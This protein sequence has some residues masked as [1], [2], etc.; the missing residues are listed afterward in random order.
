LIKL[1][2]IL[3][4]SIKNNTMKIFCRPGNKIL[5]RFYLTIL[6][7]VIL[8]FTF[9]RNASAS[10]D[11]GKV[12]VLVTCQWL[13]ENISDPSIVILHISTVIKDYDNGHIQG[14]RFLWPGWLI[15][16]NEKESVVPAELK[17]MKKVLEGLGVNDR[18]HIVLCGIY[19]NIVTVCR[20]FMTLDHIGLGGRISIL[21]GGFDEW[22]DSGRKI[23]VEH[24]TS[25]KGKLVLSIQDNLVNTDWVAQNLTNKAYSVIS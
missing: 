2:G 9:T 23:S 15:V 4:R 16:S 11:N 1:G 24:P 21:E 6:F 8:V 18:S 12:P 5:G 20:V 14:A 17:L 19:G 3:Q 13:E 22:K 25:M 7:V 10:S